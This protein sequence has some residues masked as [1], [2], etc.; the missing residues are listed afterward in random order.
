M[1]EVASELEVGDSGEDKVV[2][3][4]IQEPVDSWNS[5]QDDGEAE[6]CPSRLSSALQR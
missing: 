1:R 3:E 2:S 5:G 6:Y 4:G